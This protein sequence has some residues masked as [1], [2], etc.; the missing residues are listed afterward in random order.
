M[1][2]REITATEDAISRIKRGLSAYVSYLAACDMNSAFSEYVL[3][4]PVL[5]ILTAQG[6]AVE[7]EY[8]CPGVE[9][10]ER[11]DKKRLDFF[12]KKSGSSFA[13]EVKWA[14]S[15][16]PNVEKDVVK[17]RG[18]LKEFP[19]SRALLAV[20]GRRTYIEDLSIELGS[21]RERG[22]IICA[23]FG[24]TRYGCRVF[25]LCSPGWKSS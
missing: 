19:E 24:R 25:Q 7:C 12:A 8:E 18:F 6:Y 15:D 21:Q 14:R 17:L 2:K 20:F 22:K 13:L 4:E 3:Y 16:S 9:Q 5:R 23:D 10:P 11:G 1:A